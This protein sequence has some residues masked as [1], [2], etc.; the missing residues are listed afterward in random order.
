MN[1]A[2]IDIIVHGSIV[3]DFVS[4][5]EEFPRL[6]ETVR[7]TF[8]D[9]PG[10]KGANQAAQAALLGANVCMIGMVGNDVFGSSN[11]N[12]LKEFGVNT[13]Y[14]R[15]SERNKT[16]CATIIV[17][18]D[19]QNSIIIAPGAN[20]ETPPNQIDE[21]E[22]TIASTKMVLCQNETAHDSIK[23]IFELAKKYN[24]R[25]FFNYA[26]IDKKFDKNILKLTDIL[27]VN[28]IEGEHLSG[29]QVRTIKDALKITKILF[30]FGPSIVIMTLGSQGVVYNFEDI[31][32][33]HIVVPS[34]KVVDT[35]GAGD[36]FCGALAYFLVKR[37]E[38][39]LKEQIRRA[40][41]ISAY[42]VQRVG[43]RD[44]YLRRS[45]VPDD[46]LK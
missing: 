1:S 8:S 11:I 18:K 13:E 27:C 15:V 39:E 2:T 44:S 46:L 14:I 28:E 32:S 6:G 38:L 7:G 24:V 29:Q 26:P 16:G 9:A 36:S 34:V 19:G 33:G 10:G 12:N 45:E 25:T 30:D 3:Q 40:A 43:T 35:T 42:S 21:L 5:T 31:E 22:E 37:P 41:H 23:R 20:L 4:Y 17:T